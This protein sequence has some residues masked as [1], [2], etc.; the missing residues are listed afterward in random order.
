[1]KSYLKFLSRNKL[2]TLIEAAGLVVSLAFVI[3]IGT[4]VWQ[5]YSAAYAHPDHNRIYVLTEQRT[6]GSGYYDKEDIDSNIP[7]VEI[8]T[9]YSFA[10]VPLEINDRTLNEVPVMEV[11]KEFFELFPCTFIEGSADIFDDAFNVVVTRSFANTL[12][13]GSEGVIGMTFV[14]SR[15]EGKVFRIAAVIEDLDNPIFPSTDIIFNQ[16]NSMD[17]FSEI[18]RYMASGF[19]VTL[20]RVAENTDRELLQ[21]KLFAQFEENYSDFNVPVLHD[22][23]ELYFYEHPHHQLIYTDLATLRMLVVVV[24]ALLASAVMNYINLTFALSGKRANE[25]ATR[26]LMGAARKDI[27]MKNIMESV[28]FTM[29]CFILALLLALALEPM[30]NTLLGLNTKHSLPIA[31]RLTPAYIA[32]WIFSV[33]ALG[34]LAG[35]VPSV[36]ASHFKPI[37]VIKG[38]FRLQSKML[39][40]KCFIVVQNV[41]S[42]VLISM[43]IL[44]EAQLSHM[45]DRPMNTRTD[46]LF[47]MNITC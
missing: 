7:E 35:L 39:F 41:I 38:G 25:I 6:F 33:T 8:S 24:L 28:T 13:S 26:R 40:S 34:L 5:Q 44:M 10:T 16:K 29:V 31:I 20:F 37:D 1:M 21:E 4:Y 47:F 18:P 19:C 46:N 23:D 14:K 12:T 3:L 43:A 30:M 2:Y 45:I 27:F 9:R 22:L 32:V 36:H 15:E 11:D 17:I 42:V